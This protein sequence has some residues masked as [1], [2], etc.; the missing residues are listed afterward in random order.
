MMQTDRDEGGSTA[1]TV[2]APGEVAWRGLSGVVQGA[3]E[4]NAGMLIS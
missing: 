4:T 3:F 2:M 1:C